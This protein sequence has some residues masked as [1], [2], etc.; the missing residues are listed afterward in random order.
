[1]R[2]S[3]VISE[4]DYTVVSAGS[5]RNRV[6]N[7]IDPTTGAVVGNERIRGQADAK[8]KNLTAKSNVTKP[9]SPKP[10][11][12][13]PDSKVK[14]AVKKIKAAPGKAMYNLFL[15]SPLGRVAAVL[16]SADQLYVDLD[17]YAKVYA[18]NKCNN[19]APEVSTAQLRIIDNIS[20]SIVSFLTIGAATTA[21]VAATTRALSSLGIVVPGL[22]WLAT[23]IIGGAATVGGVGLSYLLGELAKN[24]SLVKAISTYV[25]NTMLSKET[26]SSV[27]PQCDGAV[28][29]IDETIESKLQESVTQIK[30]ASKDMVMNDPK[31]LAMLKAAKA[32]AS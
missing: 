5:G 30:T 8:A 20:G 3:Q 6:F 18:A 9:E 32:K 4:A 25:A 7:I 14:T 11:S 12:P 28:E 26:L 21:S 1:M 10:E 15:S 17:T 31:L 24:T 27:I 2:V 22:G 13:K 29:S 23:T 16:I 19:N